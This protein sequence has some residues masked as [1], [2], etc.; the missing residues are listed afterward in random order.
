MTEQT[1]ENTLLIA[2]NFTLLGIFIREQ[3][4]IEQVEA[5]NAWLEP[6]NQAIL[7]RLGPPSGTNTN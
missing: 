3:A 2:D 1:F 7:Q 6:V 5:F 4:T